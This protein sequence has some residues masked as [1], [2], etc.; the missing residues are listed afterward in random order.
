MVL[1]NSNTRIFHFPQLPQSMKQIDSVK[2]YIMI[3]RQNSQ[4]KIGKNFSG[5]CTLRSFKNVQLTYNINSFLKKIS[6]NIPDV[7]TTR[8]NTSQ[9]N[10][11]R[12]K[13]QSQGT[14][15]NVTKITATSERI[16][17]AS[18]CFSSPRTTYHSISYTIRLISVKIR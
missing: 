9:R 11:Q 3:I 1:F 13:E 16:D 2:F 12:L 4:T 18:S 10:L 14:W 7:Y 5:S 8:P 6:V 15:S 17:K